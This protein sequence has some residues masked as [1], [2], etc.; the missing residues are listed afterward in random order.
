[1]LFLQPFCGKDTRKAQISFDDTR[2]TKTKE[3]ETAEGDC[4]YSSD[5]STE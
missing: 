4:Q 1:M 5:N 3:E 2:R